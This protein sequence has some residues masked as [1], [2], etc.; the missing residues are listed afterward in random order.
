M[1]LLWLWWTVVCVVV[2]KVRAQISCSDPALNCAAGVALHNVPSSLFTSDGMDSILAL[3]NTFSMLPYALVFDSNGERWC[4]FDNFF[5]VSGSTTTLKQQF[6]T[7]LWYSSSLCRLA[8]NTDGSVSANIL[9]APTRMCVAPQTGLACAFTFNDRFCNN[10]DHSGVLATG[11]LTCEADNTKADEA[12]QLPPW[13]CVS[14]PGRRGFVSYGFTANTDYRQLVNPFPPS[15]CPNAD[16]TGQAVSMELGRPGVFQMQPPQG[17]SEY[18]VPGNTCEPLYCSCFNDW[19]GHDCQFSRTAFCGPIVNPI[20]SV[21]KNPARTRCSGTGTCSYK[22]SP[23]DQEFLAT[24]LGELTFDCCS[25]SPGILPA[26]DCVC[27]NGYYGTFCN[28][29]CV[30]N[31]NRGPSACIAMGIHAHCVV[32]DQNTGQANCVCDSD[33]FPHFDSL[34]GLTTCITCMSQGSETPTCGEQYQRFDSNGNP[35]DPGSCG[36]SGNAPPVCACNSGFLGDGCEIQQTLNYACG[37]QFQEFVTRTVCTENYL[38]QQVCF[39]FQGVDIGLPITC[40]AQTPLPSL[41]TDTLYTCTY[42]GSITLPPPLPPDTFAFTFSCND[43]CLFNTSASLGFQYLNN[44]AACAAIKAKCVLLSTTG[45]VSSQSENFCPLP[46]IDPTPAPAPSTPPCALPPV[47][48]SNPSVFCNQPSSIPLQAR[49]LKASVFDQNL[50]C[51]QLNFGASVVNT[52]LIGVGLSAPAPIYRCIP[53]QAQAHYFNVE[54]DVVVTA[55]Q[56]LTYINNPYLLGQHLFD[57]CGSSALP[58]PTYAYQPM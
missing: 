20:T 25:D 7:V 36:Q 34:D 33:Y 56:R 54:C 14:I 42:T 3:P 38:Q 39:D 40:T 23:Y 18:V 29:T 24:S 32:T 45:T 2:T 50:F 27:D 28:H 57:V 4:G 15:W 41:Y 58:L 46:F 35:V 19:T 11:E 13:P 49:W 31:G 30:V 47:I 52:T 9:V 53:S 26:F 8:T 22:D 37:N 10:T 21:Q 55:Q 44:D 6:R 43:I 1:A 48:P 16:S 12:G 51:Y 5:T 17:S